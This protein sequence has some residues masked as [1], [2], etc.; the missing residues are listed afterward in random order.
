MVLLKGKMPMY[1]CQEL[2]GHRLAEILRHF[3]LSNIKVR[4]FHHLADT[5]TN[6]GE[7]RILSYES[8]CEVVY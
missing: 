4:E 8:A 1:Q 3:G 5:E 6:Q 2:G 7:Q